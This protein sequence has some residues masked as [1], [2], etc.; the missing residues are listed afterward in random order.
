MGRKTVQD[1][2]LAAHFSMQCGL[3]AVPRSTDLE[4]RLL[5]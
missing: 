5:E 2:A 1:K 4:E 3:K